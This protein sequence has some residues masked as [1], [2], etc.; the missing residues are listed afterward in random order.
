MVKHVG[1][2]NYDLPC[3]FHNRL[4][5]LEYLHQGKVFIESFSHLHIS[6]TSTVGLG[7]GLGR[8]HIQG[9]RLIVLEDGI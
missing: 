5:A 7:K 6:S 4:F 8:E 3:F 9:S 2:S 1:I